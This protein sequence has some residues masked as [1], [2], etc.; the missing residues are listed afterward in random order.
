MV[1]PK[2]RKAA[3]KAS[4][5][6]DE[7]SDVEEEVEDEDDD[8]EDEEVAPPPAKKSRK[9]KAAKVVPMKAAKAMKATP[10][11]ATK[12]MPM[13]GAPATKADKGGGVTCKKCGKHFLK[14]G[15][16]FE[17]HQAQCTGAAEKAPKKDKE[18][19]TFKKAPKKDKEAPTFKEGS[20]AAKFQLV[21]EKSGLE[22]Q[23]VRAVMQVLEDMKKEE[24]DP[25]KKAHKMKKVK[26]MKPGSKA[27]FRQDLSIE[28]GVDGKDVVSVLE[29]LENVC[30]ETLKKQGNCVIP[31]IARLKIKV[32]KGKPAGLRW[33]P[34]AG[35][36]TQCKAIKASK[37]AKA[38]VL[39]PF[40]A[41]LS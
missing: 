41:Q 13:K 3:A 34:S 38:I 31:G 7:E 23:T 11:K 12:A 33:N 2:S 35:K 40:R 16:A 17:K 32:K 18:A 8:E 27:A 37:S 21:A 39:K 24:E 5:E 26:D 4:S 19:P 14:V 20:K 10:M 22:R 6:A 28:S 29:A 30:I 1:L 15:L 36:K 9:S 25:E